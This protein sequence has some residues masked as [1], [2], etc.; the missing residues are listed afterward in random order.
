[1]MNAVDPI[2]VPFVEGLALRELRYQICADCAAPQTLA[3]YACRYC[4]SMRLEWRISTGRGTVF[5]TAVVARAPSR[6]FQPLAPYTLALVDLDEGARLMGHAESGIS[7]GDQ[8][9]AGFFEHEGQ[10]LVRFRRL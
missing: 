8:V 9:T 6:V 2:C 5:A 7:I 3:R 10:T 4:G 1:M